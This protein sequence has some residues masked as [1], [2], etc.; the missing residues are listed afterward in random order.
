[1]FK[2]GDKVVY[3]GRWHHLLDPQK[4]Y[5]VKEVLSNPYLS[6]RVVIEGNYENKAKPMSGIRA[7]HFELV[8]NR[9]TPLVNAVKAAVSNMT[10][11]VDNNPK[12]LVALTKP[13]LSDVPP[14]GLFALGAAMSDGANK[15][16]RFNY[17]DTNVT[18]S[19]FYDAMLR[20]L[21]DWYNGEDCA[22]DSGV[23]HLGHI[24]ASCA[25]LLDAKLHNKFNDDRDKRRPDAISRNPSAWK[26]E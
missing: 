5:T 23:S 13:R 7:D 11:P 3:T 26:S 4:V 17:R 10:K 1:M 9:N 21:T 6:D 14:V 8:P 2:P 20:H 12:T 16:G 22:P 24:M 25:I 18:A 15:Y 19:V